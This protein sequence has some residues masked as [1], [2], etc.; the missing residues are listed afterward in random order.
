MTMLD[1]R[2]ILT[3][4]LVFVVGVSISYLGSHLLSP[5]SS[6][7]MGRP[8]YLT[9][10]KEIAFIFYGSSYCPAA[11]D[12]SLP[13]IIQTLIA[14]TRE[15]A[16]I[17]GYGFTTIG[18]SNEVNVEDGLAYLKNMGDFDEI[19]L[20]NGVANR[21]LQFYAWGSLDDP[22]SGATP[23]IILTKRLYHSSK[24]NS[25]DLIYPSIESETILIRKVGV[26]NIAQ[27]KG[28]TSVLGEL[29]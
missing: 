7:L 24:N 11:T 5:N 22:L 4:I 28:I 17:A 13:D 19:A 15:Q 18:I 12:A 3:A 6:T 21:A 8:T 29:L 1:S 10:E 20:G 16:H 27:L 9:N 23:Q 25:S 26:T 2:F 14:E